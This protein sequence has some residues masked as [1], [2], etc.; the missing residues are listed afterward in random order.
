[1][2]SSSGPREGDARVY[3]PQGKHP[4]VLM[5]QPT[6]FEVVEGDQLREW[7]QHLR[8]D[9]GLQ[10]VVISGGTRTISYADGHRNDVDVSAE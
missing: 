10:D 8:E 2:T 9:V 6:R 4:T 5:F 3:E 7:E 1:M